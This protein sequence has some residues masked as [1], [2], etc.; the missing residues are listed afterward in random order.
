MM[1][2]LKLLLCLI[3]TTFKNEGKIIR[4][5]SVLHTDGFR[6][7]RKC[8]KTAGARI[9]MLTPVNKPIDKSVP[10]ELKFAK[11][12]YLLQVKIFKVHI[13][14]VFKSFLI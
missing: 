7:Y 13:H 6:G 14:G 11:L 9:I 12:Y 10:L 2:S 8:L 1:N 5:I 4:T 3:E